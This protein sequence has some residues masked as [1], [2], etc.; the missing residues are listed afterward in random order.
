MTSVDI[1]D[2]SAGSAYRFIRRSAYRIPKLDRCPRC[3]SGSVTVVDYHVRTD[4]SKITIDAVVVC[5]D[6]HCP[7][8]QPGRRTPPLPPAS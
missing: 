2:T 6:P 3:G 4:D 1:H 5:H 8:Q 7:T